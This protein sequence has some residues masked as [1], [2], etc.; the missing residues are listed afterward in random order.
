MHHSQRAEERTESD[1]CAR[2]Q[3]GGKHNKIQE[4]IC[5]QQKKV[6]GFSHCPTLPLRHPSKAKRL[7]LIFQPALARRPRL[8]VSVPRP[9]DNTDDSRE[10]AINAGKAWIV[11]AFAGVRIYILYA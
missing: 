6:F 10:K 3:Q 5:A 7:P 4:R 9:L 8:R 1:S 11:H 2:A